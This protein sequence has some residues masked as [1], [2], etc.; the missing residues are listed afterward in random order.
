MVKSN[1]SIATAG[2]TTSPPPRCTVNGTKNRFLKYF[3]NVFIRNR[4]NGVPEIFLLLF[5]HVPTLSFSSLR[6]SF[7]SS[8]SADFSK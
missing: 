7:Q 5:F 8:K 4:D 1:I 3:I 6:R 2:P